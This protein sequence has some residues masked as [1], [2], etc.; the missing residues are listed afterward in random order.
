MITSFSLRFQTKGRAQHFLTQC[1]FCL[2]MVKA[3][4]GVMQ[5][6]HSGMQ[7]G[8]GALSVFMETGICDFRKYSWERKKIGDKM[9]YRTNSIISLL[10]EGR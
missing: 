1:I 8:M 10:G 4:P 7:H 9:M 5:L 6:G 2:H 3:E